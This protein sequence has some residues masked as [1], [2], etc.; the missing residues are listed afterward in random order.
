MKHFFIQNI[1]KINRADLSKKGILALRSFILFLIVLALLILPKTEARCAT[2]TYQTDYIPWSG[3]WWPKIQG[4]LATGRDYRGQPSPLQKYDYVMTGDYNGPA[5]RYGWDNY[6]DPEAVSWAGFCFCWAAAAIMENEPT[7]GGIYNGVAFRVGDKKGLLTTAYQ[8]VLYHNF[9][10]DTPAEFHWILEEYIARQKKPVIMDLA[11]GGESWNYP[12]FKYESDYTQE[13]NVRHYATTVY[14]PTDDVS[15]PDV[16]GSMITSST[17]YYY[18]VLDENGNITDSGWEDYSIEFPPKNAAEPFGTAIMNP[19]LD[20]ETIKK[21][22]YTYGDSY[23]GNESPETAVELS[24]GH[25][26][27]MLLKDKKGD[28]FKIPLKKGDKLNLRISRDAQ[29]DDTFFRISLKTYTPDSVLIA[30][31]QGVGEQLISAEQDGDYLIEITPTASRETFYELTVQHQLPYR[32]IFPLNQKGQWGTGMAVSSPYKSDFSIS[33]TLFSLVKKEGI[34]LKSFN[35]DSALRHFLGTTEEFDLAPLNGDEYIRID[36]DTPF[37]GLEVSFTENLMS[38]SNCILTEDASSSLVFPYF[39]KGS[40]MMLSWQTDL[41]IINVGGQSEKV[42]LQSYGVEGEI[43]KSDT[44][45]LL[46]GQKI[47][48]STHVFGN[49]PTWDTMSITASSESGNTSLTGYVGLSNP[50]G[51]RA[52]SS[53]GQSGDVLLVPHIAEKGYWRTEINLMNTGA[54]D[55]T[56]VFSGY[57]SEA[58]LI[59]TSEIILKA[60]QSLALDM[61]DMFPGISAEKIASARIVSLNHQSLNGMLMYET[62]QN[63][64]VAIPLS[65]SGASTLYMPHIACSEIWWTGIGIMNAGNKTADISFSL[66]AVDGRLAGNAV[67]KLKPNQRLAS[68]VRELFESES[69]A[70]GR[71]MKIASSEGQPVVGVYLIGT[72]DGRRMM[73]DRLIPRQ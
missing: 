56:V 35:D 33:R 22:A 25:Y 4:G 45:E 41:G 27:L 59:G 29:D 52:V 63:R 48:S 61:S 67:R 49:V 42:R 66:Y 47:E 73:G 6:Y 17:Y 8:G 26:V 14:Y 2:E 71:Y 51:Q 46:P 19:G 70:S 7:Q 15:S 69:L 16:V 39:E 57:D 13:G 44:V 64:F 24:S 30:E 12:I 40:D 43:L 10:L 20:Y 34:P 9:P 62:T 21:I 65:P 11:L 54:E 50:S 37:F 28:Y 60:K 72:V 23:E 36:S 31:T 1:R 53:L 55:S 68:T 18:L 38:G 3:Y 5:T 58:A 32:G